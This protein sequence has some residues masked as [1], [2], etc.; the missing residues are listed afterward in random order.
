M[1]GFGDPT[2]TSEFYDDPRQIFYCWADSIL[3]LG[4]T[5]IAGNII[6]DDDVFDDMSGSDGVYRKSLN[7]NI[8]IIN[9]FN[10]IYSTHFDGVDDYVDLGVS[11]L[12]S[13]KNTGSISAWFKLENISSS[14]NIFKTIVDSNN[15]ISLY[16]H[17]SNNELTT[18]YKGGGTA[19]ITAA[20][21]S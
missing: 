5:K 14:G 16:Y 4:I 2:F 21:F 20:Y 12:S 3:E 15:N 9:S 8:R 19:N 11:G 7:F 10:N 6:G 1:Q 17:A 18:T 13:I